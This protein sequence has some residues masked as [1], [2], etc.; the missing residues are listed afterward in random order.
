MFSVMSL[1]EYC[2]CRFY[3]HTIHIRIH[4]R[5]LLLSAICLKGSFPP[6]QY[7]RS[8]R[9]LHIDS[10]E[11]LTIWHNHN[12]KTCTASWIAICDLPADASPVIFEWTHHLKE[13]FGNGIANN[14]SFKAI[15]NWPTSSC[16]KRFLLL[17]IQ[18]RSCLDIFQ[19]GRHFG[20]NDWTN[21][22]KWINYT[23]TFAPILLYLEELLCPLIDSQK[24]P[25]I[26]TDPHPPS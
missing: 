10:P 5:R 11:E 12:S 13:Y 8:F 7:T 23:L 26:H 20:R 9:P 17:S 2:L 15:V 21:N 16:N 4:R 24:T 1:S 18:F 19:Y 3:M 6:F 25:A 14:P 22:H